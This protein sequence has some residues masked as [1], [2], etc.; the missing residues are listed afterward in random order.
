VSPYA[1]F[2]PNNFDLN[3]KS[4][5]N[6]NNLAV[7]SSNENILNNNNISQIENPKST[8]DYNIK[9]RR[10][11][12][13][14]YF[15][16]GSAKQV[17]EEI[18][19]NDLLIP[20]NFESYNILKKETVVAESNADTF[21]VDLFLKKSLTSYNKQGK[22]ELAESTFNK[23]CKKNISYLNLKNETE[24]INIDCNN[25]N[26]L[27]NDY[28][29]SKTTKVENMKKKEK[30]LLFK[31]VS[32][33]R[34]GDENK[35]VS[36]NKVNHALTNDL[37]LNR[38]N[39]MQKN[40]FSNNDRLKVL[41]NARKNDEKDCEKTEVFTD[42]EKEKLKELEEKQREKF[43]K[44]MEVQNPFK[45]HSSKNKNFNDII[46]GQKTD[47]DYREIREAY[48]K[49]EQFA[50]NF[51]NSNREE[52][53]EKVI[54]DRNQFNHFINLE[55]KLNS[56]IFYTPNIK[57]NK[58]ENIKKLERKMNETSDNNIPHTPQRNSKNLL[59]EINLEAKRKYT[60]GTDYRDS[61]TGEI[62]YEEAFTS[63][64]S[65][66]WFSEVNKVRPK[67]K[68]DYNSIALNAK[69]EQIKLKFNIKYNI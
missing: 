24:D 32:N 56:N 12:N 33:E 62:G 6:N 53:K 46:K 16:S 43:Q 13:D 52:E 35:N 44:E 10:E 27:H 37:L 64:S 61:S 48:E 18:N 38:K 5:V 54:Y 63:S 29:A 17:K 57:S 42:Y 68:L 22:K 49:R 65:T 30:D 55:T 11:S 19:L 26:T 15:K 7:C 40:I 34:K 3:L 39:E 47:K 2:S 59:R 21:N 28:V 31:I 36:E 67:N 20:N 66:D 25:I 51:L 8:S 14:L 9:E 58:Y 50:S 69:K 41:V 4:F 23:Y 60:C 45:Y 1:L